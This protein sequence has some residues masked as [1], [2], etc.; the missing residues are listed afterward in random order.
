[1]GGFVA[2]LSPFLCFLPLTSNVLKFPLC[3]I[4]GDSGKNADGAAGF[5]RSRKRAVSYFSLVTCSNPV[6]SHCSMLCKLLLALLFPPAFFLPIRTYWKNVKW[7]FLSCVLARQ[8][9]Q[10][11]KHP[12]KMVAWCFQTSAYPANCVRGWSN[13]VMGTACSGTEQKGKTKQA[14][15]IQGR[16]K[17]VCV[18]A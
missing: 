9:A 1:M 2:S 14:H 3:L 8:T 11:T 15:Y 5:C 13:K 6:D 17:S 10:A 16:V 4:E 18:V 12:T 7:T